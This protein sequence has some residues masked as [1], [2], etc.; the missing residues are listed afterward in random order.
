MF[1]KV[2]HFSLRLVHLH[3]FCSIDELSRDEK[4][5]STQRTNISLVREKSPGSHAARS[6]QAEEQHSFLRILPRDAP[7]TI[8][9]RLPI[10]QHKNQLFYIFYAVCLAARL[11]R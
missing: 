4:T 5:K 1:E 3:K 8:S 11:A 2:K 7:L 9:L 10:A 6:Y